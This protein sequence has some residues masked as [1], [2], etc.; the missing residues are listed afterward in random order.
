MRRNTWDGGKSSSVLILEIVFLNWFLH[1]NK[2]YVDIVVFCITGYWRLAF[3]CGL[4]R[5]TQGQE[6]LHLESGH[7][8]PRDRKL[9]NQI[10][11]RSYMFSLWLAVLRIFIVE[12]S[13]LYAKNLGFEEFICWTW[14]FYGFSLSCSFFCDSKNQSHHMKMR[15]RG[16]VHME[17]WVQE[18]L[19]RNFVRCWTRAAAANTE[20]RNFVSTNKLRSCAPHC[21]TEHSW[22]PPSG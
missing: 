11:L 13:F 15:A 9:K 10:S 7:C 18:T 14:I 22:S 2:I 16:S 3:D 8:K 6:F 1:L 4:F 20:P 19:L 17:I 5:C 21:H 12:S